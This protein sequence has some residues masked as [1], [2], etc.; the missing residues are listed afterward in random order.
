MS[1]DVF[2][3]DGGFVHE[4]A[5]GEGKTAESHDVDSLMAE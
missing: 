2:Y 3:G 4:N 5:D 1:V